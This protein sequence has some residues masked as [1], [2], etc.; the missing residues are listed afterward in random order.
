[1]TGP[2]WMRDKGYYRA[3]GRLARCRASHFIEAG[4][5]D[6]YRQLFAAERAAAKRRAHASRSTIDIARYASVTLRQMWGTLPRTARSVDRVAAVIMALDDNEAA[7]V[8]R[9]G[10]VRADQQTTRRGG[11]DPV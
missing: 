4:V 10:D 5:V 8:A 2:D 6:C 1:M 7:F 11:A 3:A 9:Y